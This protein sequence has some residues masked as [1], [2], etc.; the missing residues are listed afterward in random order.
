MSYPATPVT[1][2]TRYPDRMRRDAD[3][4]HAIL[5]EALYCHLSFVVDGR[6]RVLPTLHVRI[7]DTLYVH[8]STGS[9]PMLAGRRTPLREGRGETGRAA[10]IPVSVAVTLLDGLV[11]ARSQFHHSANY[12]SVV[13]HG[14]AV[15]VADEDTRRRVL[16]ALVDKIA[17][18]RAAD[19]RPPT[20]QELAATAVLALPLTDAAAKVRSGGAND[21]EADLALPYWAGVLP[22]RTTAGAPEPTDEG[23]VLP[24]YLHGWRRGDAGE[25][26]PWYEAAP[27]AGRLVRL[28]PLSTAHVDDLYAASRDREVWRHLTGPWPETTADMA[29]EV[30]TAL[31]AQAAG[32][33]V[34][35]AQ[36]D[37]ATG[38]AVGMTSY[39]DIAPDSRRVEIGYTWLGRAAWRTGINTEA[40]LM[41]L[42]R[43]F[44]ELGA[45]RVSLRTDTANER[46]QRAIERLG[47]KRDGV[48]RNYVIRADG[49]PR[50]RV[51]YSMTD[52]EWP[53]AR[54]RLRGLLR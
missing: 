49:T 15:P 13:A 34:T 10:G 43:A 4:V 50:D 32:S 21:D 23:T 5:D 30:D 31:R 36:I 53:D 44:E 17:A 20:R 2:P 16:A 6:P 26:S 35:W 51:V 14:T 37:R 48:F 42:T 22:L 12:R 29:R 24:A 38:R 3:T 41:L 40:K 54:D 46:S 27:M 8:G 33:R 52:V 18:G 1:T 45:I 19:S 39:Y 47:M 11:F 25:R 28:E 7:G 9:R